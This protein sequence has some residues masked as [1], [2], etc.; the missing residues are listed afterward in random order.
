MEW[1][2]HVTYMYMR[3]GDRQRYAEGFRL[4]GLSE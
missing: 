1:I 4:A 3:E 2:K